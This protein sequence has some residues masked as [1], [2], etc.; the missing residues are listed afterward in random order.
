MVSKVYRS[1]DRR[2]W[3]E[4]AEDV[5]AAIENAVSVAYDHERARIAYY[6]ALSR[7]HDEHDRS[8]VGVAAP[9]I[10]EDYRLP[11]NVLRRIVSTAHARLISTTPRPFYCSD[12]GDFDLRNKLEQLNTAV[13]GLFLA[14]KADNYANLATKHAVL[15]G[16]GFVKIYPITHTNKPRIAIERVYPWEVLVDP[17]DALYGDPR[18]FFQVRWVDRAQLLSLWSDH[19]EILLSADAHCEDWA[20]WTRLMGD[21]VRVVEAWHLD[22][23]GGKGRHV[24][25]VSSGALVDEPYPYDATPLVRFQYETPRTGYWSDGLAH[26]VAGQQAELNDILSAISETIRRG[27]WPTVLVEKNSEVEVGQLNND[28]MKIVRYRGVA[29]Q[30]QVAG[31]LTSEAR[32]YASE[33]ASSMF[34]TSGISQY[35]AQSV[36]PAGLQSG[37]ALRIFA[38]QQ[39]GNLREASELRAQSYL[40]LGMALVRAQRAV[41]EVDPDSKIIFSDP[42]ERRSVSLRWKDIDLPDTGLEMVAAPVSILPSTPAA[43][44]ASLEELMNAGVLTPEEFRENLDL[45]DLKALNRTAT[46]P[47]RVIEMQLLAIVRDGEPQMPEPFFPLDL[48]RQLAAQ[49]YCQAQVD[50]VSEDRLELL[51]R[52]IQATVDLAAMGQP[53]AQEQPPVDGQ[54]PVEGEP[55]PPEMPPP[56][57]MP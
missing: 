20:S 5:H 44:A 32:Q 50:G 42:K 11:R 36:K 41:S 9:R 16:D 56:E 22:P 19:R 4:D 34:E 30:I 2:W 53:P 3:D 55:L 47:R 43:K 14:H 27:A 10:D 8:L 1:L 15:Y 35:A 25:A 48:A 57:P 52:Y 51:R 54:L 46:A 7:L 21:P 31:G 49:H 18:S 6:R 29:P 45:P 12:G 28:P 33:I 39:D 37:R 23:D 13:H 17:L 26:Q 24:V 38:D 40:A